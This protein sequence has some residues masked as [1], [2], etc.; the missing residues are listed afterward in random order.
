[1]NEWVRVSTRGLR[2][3]L[4]LGFAGHEHER[5]ARR[6]CLAWACGEREGGEDKRMA[7]LFRMNGMSSMRSATQPSSVDAQRDVSASY[8]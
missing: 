7:N 8:I 5:K 1:M 2:F 4:W 6:G 3:E